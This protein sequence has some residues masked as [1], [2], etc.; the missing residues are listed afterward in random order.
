MAC[1]QLPLKHTEVAL[2]RHHVCPK[3]QSDLQNAGRLHPKARDKYS[4]Q[5]G[6]L[7]WSREITEPD[8]RRPPVTSDDHEQTEDLLAK[9][10]S[11]VVRTNT[12][13]AHGRR[14]VS[15]LDP[16]PPI[17]S[18]LRLDSEVDTVP[19]DVAVQVGDVV[20]PLL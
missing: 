9:A 12:V 19:V 17:V 8:F 7:R 4:S 3:M 1:R 5:P 18:D 6:H 2:E 16:I 10:A 14:A 11:V 15:A 13:C 20:S